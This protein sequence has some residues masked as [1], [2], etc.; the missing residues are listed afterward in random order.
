MEDFLKVSQVPTELKWRRWFGLTCEGFLARDGVES[1]EES[2]CEGFANFASAKIAFD[3]RTS[4]IR[5]LLDPNLNLKHCG[6]L[7]DLLQ[8]HCLASKFEE[9]FAERRNELRLHSRGRRQHP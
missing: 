1:S 2:L 4:V 5:V 9:S 8:S 3:Q 6:R 7:T